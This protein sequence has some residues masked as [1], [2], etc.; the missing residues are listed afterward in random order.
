MF[1]VWN[2]S[3][4]SY[5]YIKKKLD[6]EGWGGYTSMRTREENVCFQVCHQR[7]NILNTVRK[8]DFKNIYFRFSA[9]T[10]AIYT[11]HLL[12]WQLIFY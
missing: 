4:C 3:T 9:L 8:S 12:H 7:C 10:D 1:R 5:I 2:M 6:K 11:V